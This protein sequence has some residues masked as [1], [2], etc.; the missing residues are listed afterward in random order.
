MIEYDGRRGIHLGLRSE[1]LADANYIKDTTIELYELDTGKT[2][3]SNGVKWFEMHPK[4]I[5]KCV[6]SPL[7]N[8]LASGLKLS[9]PTVPDAYTITV[10]D[11]GSFSDD[12]V[13]K[14][15]ENGTDSRTFHAIVL[16]KNVNVLTLDRPVD[17]VF[18]IDATIKIINPYASVDGSITRVIFEN[19]NP[20]V[21]KV[22][23][24]R[25]MF[26]MVTEN[27]ALFDSFG[28]IADGLL[29]GIELRKKNADGTFTNYFNAKTNNRLQLL[30]YDT[31]PFDPTH[32]QAVNGLSGRMTW[33]K[34]GSAIELNQGESLQ[35][36]VQDD[37]RTIISL[38]MISEGI[39]K[40]G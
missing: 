35:M 14:V 2:Y 31:T 22:L 5:N 24:N 39:L 6:I 36:L 4:K 13:I 23:I 26:N 16:S 19:E 1:R 7:A 17:A 38:E 30:M 3:G 25:I 18:T 34:F 12:N 11:G 33:E 29:R 32:P 27:P 28:D 9:I 40:Q 10:S 37:L 15:E 21:S 8:V 20:F